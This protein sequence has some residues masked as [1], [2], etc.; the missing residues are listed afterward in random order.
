MNSSE[1]GSSRSHLPDLQVDSTVRFLRSEAAVHKHA[2][3]VFETRY[4]RLFEAAK[5]AF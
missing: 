5:D 3:E 1:A 4:R 2:L